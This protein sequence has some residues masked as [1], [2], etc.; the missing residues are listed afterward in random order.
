MPF[1][2]G[3]ELVVFPLLDDF[4]FLEDDDDVG[5]PDSGEPEKKE[6]GSKG[7]REGRERGRVK[8]G[9]AAQFFL[10]GRRRSRRR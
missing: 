4:P 6:G 2:D 9:L 1:F 7:G 10:F 8:F 3:H 5:G